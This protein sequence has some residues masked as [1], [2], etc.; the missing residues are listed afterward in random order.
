MP[1]DFSRLE[2][3]LLELSLAKPGLSVWLMLNC[4]H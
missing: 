4:I 1:D 2:L 3:K